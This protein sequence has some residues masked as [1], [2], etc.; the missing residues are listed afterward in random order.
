[1]EDGG[2][3]IDFLFKRNGQEAKPTP[4]LIILDLN[5]PKVNGLEFLAT[6]KSNKE[7]RK[8]PVLVLST[9]TAENDIQQA[10][11][12]H[13]NCYLT[14]PVDL[15]DFF[16]LIKLIGRYWFGVTQLPRLESKDTPS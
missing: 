13:A 1:V 6:V 16:E 10:Y 14:K 12:L 8:L 4:D 9:S 15:N 3:A 5:L 11:D 2:K 7:F